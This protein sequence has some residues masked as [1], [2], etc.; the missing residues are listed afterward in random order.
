MALKSKTFLVSKGDTLEYINQYLENEIGLNAYLIKEIQA[1]SL[2]ETLTQLTILFNKYP[3]DLLDSIAPREGAIFTSDVASNDFDIRFLF[4][5]PVDYRSVQ[6][7]TF[8]IDGVGLPTSKIY[9]DPDCNNY[10]LKISASGNSFQSEAFHSYQISSSLKREDGSSFSYT[11]V[12]GYVFHSLS[13]AHIGDYFSDYESRKRGK[14]SIGVLR[15]SKGLNPQQGLIEYLS[16]R[17]ISED[18]LIAHNVVSTSQN[19][20]DIYFIYLKKIE[21]QIVSG[22]PLNNSLLPDVSAPGKVTLVFNVALDKSKLLS[23]PGLFTIESG[24]SSSTPVSPSDI[25]LLEDLRTVEIN[26]SSYFTGQKVYSILA[27]PGILGLDGLAKEKPEQWT[28]HISAYE[29]GAGGTGVGAPL[30]AQYL[31]YASDPDLASATVITGNVNDHLSNTSNPHGTTAGQVGAPTI[32][33]FSGHTGNFSNPHGTTASQVGAP[34]VSDFTGH[35]GITGIHFTQSQI[36]I[37]ASQIYDFASAVTGYLTGVSGVSN[38]VFSSHTGDTSIHFTQNQIQHS[39]LQGLTD[40]HHPQYILRDGS[41]FMTGQLTSSVAAVD[42]AAYIRKYESEQAD[43]A[44]Y[45]AA[46]TDLFGHTSN[47]SNPHSTTAAQVGSPTIAEFTGHTGNT[48]VH[49]TQSQISIPSTQINNFTEAVQDVVG[50]FSAG[51][52]G[53]TAIYNDAGNTLTYGLSGTL[54]TGL[55]GHLNNT[56][57]HFT[58]SQISI[59]STQINNFTEAVQD[60]VGNASF[61]L[62]ASGVTII[63][64]DASNTLTFGFSGTLYTGLTGH[65]N[66]TNNPH[67][68]TAAQV[69]APTTAQFTGH[70][71]SSYHLAFTSVAGYL[72]SV[73]GGSVPSIIDYDTP[74]KIV[75]PDPGDIIHRFNVADGSIVKMSIQA[76]LDYFA[77]YFGLT[78]P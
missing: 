37:P 21:P 23:T 8:K 64:N 1:V 31:L 14:I 56:G 72:G 46:A 68:T 4:N 35:T 70:T 19:T 59:P 12:G 29:P 66:N 26:V 9:L 50:A 38:G 39:G 49:F 15:L 67:A 69:G 32:S 43:I 3:S 65:L 33:Q 54:Y 71:G 48:G 6:S 40:D 28:I 42:P 52:S 61:S 45:L 53:I 62:G 58:Q 78:P 20:S 41:R 13:N 25:A 16:Q 10:Y 18:R 22:F 57:I 73:T 60:V 7:G 17:Q 76:L 24:F 11:P 30:D 77:D 47:T 2:H 44:T 5:Y 55:T 36:S 63:Y 34:T 75:P 51:Q 27:R 74:T